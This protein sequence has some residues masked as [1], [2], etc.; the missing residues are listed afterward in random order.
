DAL[1]DVRVERPLYEP[2]RVLDLVRFFVEDV[3][4]DLADDLSLLLRI[5][6]A[7]RRRQELLLRVGRDQVEVERL[8]EGR[9]D[10]LLLA[11]TKEPVV[12]EDA[13]EALAERF[14]TEHR[15]DGRIDAAREAANHALV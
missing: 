14:V 15:R 1:D 3:D 5:G 9:D 10:L 4:E 8:A 11:L 2:L 12:D 13:R 6:D 7:A